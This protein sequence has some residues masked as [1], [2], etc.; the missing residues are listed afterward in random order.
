MKKRLLKKRHLLKPIHPNTVYTI[1]DVSV[2]PVSV[3]GN[4][5]PAI[6]KIRYDYFN[7]KSMDTQEQKK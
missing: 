5:Q 2:V 7:D 6:L 1:M 4:I 3:N